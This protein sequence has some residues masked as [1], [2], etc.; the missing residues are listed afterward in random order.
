[1]TD[2]HLTEGGPAVELRLDDAVGDALQASGVVGAV[3]LG[4]GRWEVTPTSKVGVAHI[5]G[6][7]LWLR[8]KVP[9]DRILF[10]LG[11][12]RNPGWRDDT[13]A[14][15]PVPELLPALAVAFADQAERALARGLLQGYSEVEDSVTVLRGRLR[16]QEQLSRRFGIA[17][18]LLVRYDDHTVDT[19]ENRLLRAAVELLLRVPGVGA[20]VRVRLRHLRQVLGEVTPPVRGAPLPTWTPSRLNARYHVALWLAEVLLARNALDQR[21]GAVRVSGFIVDMARVFEDFLTAALTRAFVAHGGHCSAQEP[22]FLDVAGAV[23]M[24]PDI[25]WHRDGVPAAVIDAKYKAEKPSGFPDADLYQMLA[26]CTAMRLGD[27]HLVYAKG[28]EVEVSHTVRNAGVRIHGHTL[29]LAAPPADLM[30]QV[31]HLAWR[32]ADT[33]RSAEAVHA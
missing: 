27:G 9:I 15:D 33:A 5:A 32:I 29:D 10:L 26:Y 17:I 7:T 22:H 30:A 19:P 12:A 14:M 13:V 1:V 31:D 11:Y 6:L 28:N 8:P 4:G 3:R 24:K 23:R 2:L 20:R 25:V 16:E 21:P 18:P